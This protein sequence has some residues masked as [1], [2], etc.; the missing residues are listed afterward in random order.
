MDPLLIASIGG[1]AFSMYNSFMSLK[2]S[3]KQALEVQQLRLQEAN[4]LAEKHKA[5][6][7]LFERKGNKEIALSPLQYGKG[8]TSSFGSY[9][10]KAERYSNLVNNLQNMQKEADFEVSLRQREASLAGA[11]AS[12]YNRAVLPTLLGGSLQA[13]G[14]F[15]KA[16]G[17]GSNATY[18]VTNNNYGSAA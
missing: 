11:Q 17:A 16:S 12:A 14:S 7:I 3:R 4:M 9:L 5:N 2:E 8:G 10:E 15:Y 6:S 13:A 1:T 18:N